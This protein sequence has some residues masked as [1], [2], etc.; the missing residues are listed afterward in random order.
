VGARF[1]TV[2]EYIGSFPDDVQ[3]VLGEVRRAI[4]NAVP[5]AAEETI[6]YQIPTITLNG[7]QV[8]HFAAWKHH[9]AVYPIP[10]TDDTLAREIAPYRDA[11]S[12]LRF[13][14]GKP[15]PYDL[16]ER[17]VALLVARRA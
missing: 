1:S 5:A 4:H 2:D 16:V 3:T 6:S 17:L 12:T 14:Y 15:I 7:R 8:V 13:P 11:K 10:E 9:L